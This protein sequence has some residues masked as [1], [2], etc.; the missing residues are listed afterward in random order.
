M[1]VTSNK[2]RVARNEPGTVFGRFNA[3]QTVEHALSSSWSCRSADRNQM[4]S[5][6]FDQEES[7]VIQ[8]NHK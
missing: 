2:N 1:R 3:A 4:T 5:S 8:T 6:M 7:I